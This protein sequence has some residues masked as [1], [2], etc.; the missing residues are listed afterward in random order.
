MDMLDVW[1]IKWTNKRSKNQL[2]FYINLKRLSNFDW[3]KM[4]VQWVKR[5]KASSHYV[6]YVPRNI[7]GEP[8]IYPEYG[9]I[10]K[11]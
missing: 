4:S 10:K 7:V 3:F 2:F 6:G 9:D 8:E 11:S 1:P 5:A